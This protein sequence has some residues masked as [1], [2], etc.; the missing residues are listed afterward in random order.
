MDDT[1]YNLKQKIAEL[2]EEIERLTT[3]QTNYS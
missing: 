2:Q 1:I 3:H